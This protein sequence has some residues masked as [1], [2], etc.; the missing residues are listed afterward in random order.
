MKM[1]IGLR[2]TMSMRQEESEEDV[3]SRLE[4]TLRQ[5][6]ANYVG[7]VNSL[8][9][10]REELFRPLGEY[11]AREVQELSSLRHS[12][13]FFDE[14]ISGLG[15]IT[16]HFEEQKEKYDSELMKFGKT[17]VKAFEKYKE[18]VH[19]EFLDVFGIVANQISERSD[20]VPEA[21]LNRIDIETLEK[22]LKDLTAMEKP[23]AKLDSENPVAV[24]YHNTKQ[25]LENQIE[26]AKNI[27]DFAMSSSSV[28]YPVKIE[29]WNGGLSI[30]YAMPKGGNELTDLFEQALKSVIKNVGRRFNA[31]ADLKNSKTV[32]IGSI[33]QDITSLLREELE[34]PDYKA[35]QNANVNPV[36]FKIPAVGKQIFEMAEAGQIGG[37]KI[38]TMPQVMEELGIS[39]NALT[40]TL[41]HQNREIFENFTFKRG[42]TRF[43]TS[44]GVRRIKKARENILPLKESHDLV[45]K[46]SDQIVKMY[47]RGMKSTDIAKK[48]GVVYSTIDRTLAKSGV[49]TPIRVK[50]N[51]GTLSK[52]RKAEFEGILRYEKQNIRDEM[53]EM[54]IDN[55]PELDKI[56][57]FGLEGPNFGSYITLSNLTGIDAGKSVVAERDKR[58]YNLMKS[59]V[60]NC[61]KIRGG[62]IFDGLS[63]YSGEAAEALDINKGNRFNFVN[64]D[65]MGPLSKNKVRT[66]DKLFQE[67]RIDD[68]SVLFVTLSEHK[69]FTEQLRN[70]LDDMLP[71]KYSSIFEKG[72]QEAVFKQYLKDVAAE[73]NYKVTE[74]KTEHYK[75]RKCPM[76]FMGYKLE[77]KK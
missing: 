24:T 9:K 41:N 60:D 66:I 14:I 51:Y 71:E 37:Q 2:Q 20:E 33:D 18:V 56:R 75:S 77:K 6:S 55:L 28:L 59:I 4:N 42:V 40:Y 46:K 16:E 22:D 8:N 23:I 57:Y 53:L 68:D 62:K 30:E 11:F 27:G 1:G 39:K 35:L 63:L 25:D 76:L 70:N 48:I 61:D 12:N 36:Y 10:Q 31:T 49:I 21:I 44:E 65:Y 54:M 73:N 43:I 69:R 5:E 64:L 67:D 19:K 72:G 47:W 45:Q 29:Q 58:A 74:I 26:E 15:S 34:K 7:A 52:I 38:Y 17:E 13:R 32:R 3:V 50:K